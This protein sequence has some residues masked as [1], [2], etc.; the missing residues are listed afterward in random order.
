MKRKTYTFNSNLR[1]FDDERAL[2]SHYLRI[3]TALALAAGLDEA[4][5]ANPSLPSAFAMFKRM[6]ATAR[7][8]GVGGAS[9]YP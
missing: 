2:R 8:V 5:K 4:V 6:M 9:S 1:T 3:G 7:A